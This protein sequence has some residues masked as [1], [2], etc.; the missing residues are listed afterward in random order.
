MSR[1]TT[2]NRNQMHVTVFLHP[3]TEPMQYLRNCARIRDL[4]MTRLAQLV[5]NR[6]AEDQLIEA[7]L[8]D[9]GQHQRAKHERRYRELVS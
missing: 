5:I 8:D 3:E 6:V 7:V 9:A 4:S 1:H 2:R